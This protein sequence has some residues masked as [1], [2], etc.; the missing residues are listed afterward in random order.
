MRGTERAQIEIVRSHH[1]LDA[2][3]PA[4]DRAARDRQLPMLS[5]AWI[6]ACA[7]TLHAGDALRVIT[8]SRD[9][10]LAAA[11]PLV[12]CTRGGAERLELMGAASLY[13]P[14]DLIYDS[15]GSLQA[16]LQAM[17]SAK[18]PVVLSR[19]PAQSPILGLLSA[20]PARGVLWSKPVAGTLAVRTD[21][22]WRD[23]LARLS[24]QRR[25]DLRRARRRAEEA[26]RVEIRMHRPRPEEV[27]PMLAA[28]V[29]VEAAGWKG[30]NGSSL[31]H[32]HGLRAFFLEY[33]RL[34][35]AA[36][37]LRFSFLDVDGTPVAGQ[38]SVEYA[39]RLWVLKIGYDEAWSRC[40]PGRLLLAETLQ[41]AIERRLESYEFLGTD[42]P[43]LHGWDAEARALSTVACYPPTVRGMYGL[44]A[45]VAARV[46]A[47]AA[48]LAKRAPTGE[49]PHHA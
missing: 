25:Y 7:R 11:A 30:R 36:G 17:L 18:R 27:E 10:A 49:G 8:V 39:D 12:A 42:E 41:D 40:S 35:A 44:A 9:G 34:A 29:R 6:L 2:L 43:W 26:G 46:R 22:N 15:D 21:S 23:Y 45:D 48:S 37:E 13:E 5:H 24:S 47:R 16:L 19:I 28:F 20:N 31:S 4:W 3:A 14:S 33:G 1:A 32:R 38:L